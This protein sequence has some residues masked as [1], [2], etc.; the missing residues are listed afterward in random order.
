MNPAAALLGASQASRRTARQGRG[1]GAS[2][3]RMPQAS[4]QT[5]RQGRGFGFGFIPPEARVAQPGSSDFKDVLRSM[6]YA[7]GG[8]G[9]RRP[10]GSFQ[11]FGP[12]RLGQP[13]TAFENYTRVAP[14]FAERRAAD[15][16]KYRPRAQPMYI[17]P[18]MQKMIDS[19]ETFKMGNR[20]FRYDRRGRPVEVNPDPANTDMRG[21]MMDSEGR[22]TF[23]SDPTKKTE[24]QEFNLRNFQQA[25]PGVTFANNAGFNVTRRSGLF[26]ESA[27]TPIP[28]VFGS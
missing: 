23:F 15:P 27:F 12:V 26:G 8:R 7:E 2:Q 6:G 5:A 19:E 9:I 1:F 21:F 20:D 22:K 28:K 18:E 4:Q 14:S 11:M 24:L 3:L 25:R 13:D 17:S 10:D 16:D